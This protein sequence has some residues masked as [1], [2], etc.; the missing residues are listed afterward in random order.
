[1]KVFTVDFQ[2]KGVDKGF[3]KKVLKKNFN[4]KGLHCS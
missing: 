1:M 2:K 3:E 4:K